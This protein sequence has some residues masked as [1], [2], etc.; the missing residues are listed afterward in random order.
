MPPGH[1][2]DHF[3][4]LLPLLA[5]LAALNPDALQALAT[6]LGILVSLKQLH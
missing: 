6:A 5:A 4:A 2:H 1:N 3:Y